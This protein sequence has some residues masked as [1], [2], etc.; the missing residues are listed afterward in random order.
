MVYLLDQ[1]RLS[2]QIR[3]NT[4]R[5]GDYAPL[6][7]GSR[8]QA[9]E[10]SRVAGEPNGLLPNPV[11]PPGF[12]RKSGTQARDYLVQACQVFLFCFIHPATA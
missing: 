8:V 3:T 9:S 10:Q 6:Q 2:D 1:T 5:K 11:E 7:H 4:Q 12:H